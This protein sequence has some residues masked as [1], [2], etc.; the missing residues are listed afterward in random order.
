MS[1]FT[2]KDS[3]KHEYDKSIFIMFKSNNEIVWSFSG[4][5]LRRSFLEHPNEL[6]SEPIEVAL[7]DY[8]YEKLL[9]DL[10]NF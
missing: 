2:I 3:Y 5:E 6:C 9:D 1:K 4:N 8:V 7:P 10:E